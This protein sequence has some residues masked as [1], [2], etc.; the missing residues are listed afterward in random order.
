MA[1]KKKK[2]KKQREAKGLV[3]EFR[4]LLHECGKTPYWIAKNANVNYAT[5]HKFYHSRRDSIS[6]TTAEKM[7]AVL[8]I[9]VVRKS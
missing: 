2:A 1:K 5:V 7:A 6:L 4:T 9:H 8:D 3:D